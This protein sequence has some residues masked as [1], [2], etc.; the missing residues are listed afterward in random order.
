MASGDQSEPKKQQSFSSMKVL[1]SSLFFRFL[2]LR[3]TT[4]VKPVD[5]KDW[6]SLLIVIL[7]VSEGG[8]YVGVQRYQRWP[9]FVSES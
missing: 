2:Y 9:F 8:S 7:L 6:N 1:P 3:S 5:L 4:T